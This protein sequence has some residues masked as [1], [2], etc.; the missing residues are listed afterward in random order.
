MTTFF[1]DPKNLR[2]RLST[3]VPGVAFLTSILTAVTMTSLKMSLGQYYAWLVALAVFSGLSSLA[4]IFAMT[5]PLKDLITK[6]EGL[7]RVDKVRSDRG[8]MIE[9]YQ[10]IE[11]LMELAK[12]REMENSTDGARMI[13]GI[14]RLDYLLPLGY[15][16]LMVAHEVRNPLNTITGMN[17]LLKAK[18]QDPQFQKYIQV[19]LDAAKKIDVFT[20]DL[21]DFTDDEVNMEDFD[22][23]GVVAESMKGLSYEFNQVVCDFEKGNL[24]TF[25]GDRNKIYQAINNILKN[26][27][28]YERD[29]GYVKVATAFDRS[30]LISIYNR[31][32]RVEQAIVQTIFKPFFT[33]KKGGRGIG[34]FIA[35]RNVK[36]HGGNI[37]VTSSDSGTI[38]TITLPVA[39]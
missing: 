17:E 13:E 35:M 18:T 5:S 3:V 22:I 20:K 28:E 9:V 38:F 12:E 37:D 11:K 4:I 6:A 10:L 21:L 27:F 16:S 33:K 26:A 19:S 7:V 34:L 31:S 25:S 30:M 15:M 24:P 32:S 39:G 14:E 8:L 29:G 2:Y 36:M 1:K 23:N